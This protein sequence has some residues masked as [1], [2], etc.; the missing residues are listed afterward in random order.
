MALSFV[1]IYFFLREKFLS[2]L[3]VFFMAAISDFFD[4]YLARKFQVSSEMGAM[5]DPIADKILMFASYLTLAYTNMIPIYV[6]TV[7]IL[8]DIFIVSVV[9][10]CLIQKVQIKISPLMSSKINT[11][12]QLLFV[13]SVLACK[14]FEINVPL[15]VFVFMV[16]C[17]TIYSGMD[18]ASRYSWIKNELLGQ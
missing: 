18:Y 8:R 6:A 12:I 9:A 4:G 2:A 16:C 14:A 5:L 7:V 10:F 11:A 17:S 1:F 13:V 3:V 15:N